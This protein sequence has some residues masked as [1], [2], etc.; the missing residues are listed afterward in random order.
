MSLF[1]RR[2]Y[3]TLPPHE[4]VVARFD[5]LFLDLALVARCR[6]CGC[7][8]DDACPGG[9]C[10]VEDP[11][12][13]GDLCSSCLP[14]VEAMKRAREAGPGDK[15]VAGGFIFEK[16]E[17]GLIGGWQLQAVGPLELED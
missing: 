13:M 17:D 11:M 10:W 7:T 14:A 16:G 5:A 1:N 3:V 6:V 15:W 9:C 12:E 4:E 2:Q 8:E